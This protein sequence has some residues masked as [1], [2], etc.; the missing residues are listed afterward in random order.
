MVQSAENFNASATYNYGC[1]IPVEGCLDQG[2]PNFNLEA[3]IESGGCANVIT[4]LLDPEEIGF[5]VFPNPMQDHLYIAPPEK[6]H[7]VVEFQL[8]DLSGQILHSGSFNGSYLLKRENL[9][10]GAY[11]LCLTSKKQLITKKILVH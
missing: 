10:P 11:L 7:E 6:F 5:S 4:S 8:I 3:N 2:S 9:R 1:F